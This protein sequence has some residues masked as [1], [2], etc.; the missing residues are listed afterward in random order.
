MR[1][2]V[3]LVLM[4]TAAMLAPSGTFA[5]DAE[6]NCA[7]FTTQEDAQDFFD[8]HG[9]SKTNNVDFL[10]ADHDGIACEHLSGTSGSGTTDTGTNSGFPWLW[11]GLGIVGIGAAGV[12]GAYVYRL[13]RKAGEPVALPPQP[14]PLGSTPDVTVPDALPCDPPPP[15]W[16]DVSP[17]RAQE[18][19]AMPD[20]TYR[21]TPEWTQR[22][23]A[24]LHATGDRCHLCGEG[25]PLLPEHVHDR[26]TIRRGDE[27]PCD[28]VVLCDRCAA[29]LG[30]T[31][32]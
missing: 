28:L 19:V 17:A 6:Q 22:A 7:T 18:L 27:L 14:A 8:A 25:E 9:G 2:I 26:T 5:R 10:D 3:T 1:R 4:L 11:A 16:P 31:P 21:A 23:E 20:A 29:Q 30:I 32:G 15:G 12:G 24:V 13:S